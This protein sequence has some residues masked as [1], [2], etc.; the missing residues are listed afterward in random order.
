[1]VC[2]SDAL[3]EKVY[4]AMAQRY[5]DSGV[6]GETMIASILYMITSGCTASTQYAY[7]EMLKEADCAETGVSP[8]LLPKYARHER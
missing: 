2:I 7:A 5:K 6:F 8:L 3:F 1:M 4:P